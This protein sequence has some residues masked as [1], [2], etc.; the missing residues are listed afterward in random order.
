[1]NTSVFLS[2]NHKDKK[3]VRRL[4]RDIECHGIRVWLDEAEMNIGDSLVQ[5]IREGIDNVDYFAVVLSNNSI[6]APWVKNELDVAI[7]YQIAGRLKVLPIILENVELPSFLIGKLY[8]NFSDPSEYTNELEKVI[9]SMGVAFNKNVVTP[10][11]SSNLGSS[12]DS[13]IMLGLPIMSA[14][15]HR[16]YQYLGMQVDEVEKLVDVKANEARNIIVEN[17]LCKMV[18]WGEGNFI[19]FVE[20]ELLQTA[21]HSQEQEFDSEALLGALSIGVHELDLARKKTHFHTY[22]DH[23]KKMKVTASCLFDG[24]PLSVSFGTKY[25]NM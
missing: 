19:S 20:I 4:A 1:M 5:K 16:P 13:A 12:L 11:T 14:P 21:P 23:K 8:S 2:H 25:Y 9:K 10:Q 7:N 17:D 6:N 18:L 22:Y 15:F 3:F 24:A